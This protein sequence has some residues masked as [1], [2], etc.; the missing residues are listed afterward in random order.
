MPGVVALNFVAIDERYFRGDGLKQ[1]FQLCR[2][3]LPVTIRVEN[4]LFGG[5]GKATAQGRPVAEIHG[6]RDDP[7]VRGVAHPHFFQNFRGGVC[8]AVVHDNHFEVFRYPAQRFERPREQGLQGH[9]VIISGKEDTEAA[10]EADSALPLG[11]PMDHGPRQNFFHHPFPHTNQLLRPHE[12]LLGKVCHANRCTV[13]VCKE[14]I[15]ER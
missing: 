15:K 10:S 11:R 7:E 2:I 6:M 9:R 12:L 14:L 3:I 5:G 8:A 4:E 1:V 13:K